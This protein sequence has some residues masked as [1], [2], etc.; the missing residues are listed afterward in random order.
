MMHDSLPWAQRIT[1]AG[2]RIF[3]GNRW[4]EI[5]GKLLF[6]C[7]KPW[8]TAAFPATEK[9]P[10]DFLGAFTLPFM[11]DIESRFDP[12]ESSNASTEKRDFSFDAV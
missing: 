1:A 6:R 11:P 8:P 10:Q 7:L 4:G 12:C 5:L 9:A 2:A 3:R